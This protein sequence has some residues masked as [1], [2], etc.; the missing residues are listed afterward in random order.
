M[1]TIERRFWNK[2]DWSADESMCWPWLAATQ[3]GY[4]K[5][6]L[7]VFDGVGL[8]GYAHRVAY[9]LEVGPVPEG[10]QLDH[11]CRNRACVNPTHLEPVTARENTRRGEHVNSRKTH[12]PQAHP[13][14]EVNTYFDSLGWRHCRTCRGAR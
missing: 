14:D 6:H 5:F 12:C 3:G 10:L 13:Y 11:L 7:G 1:Q 9:E 8:L 2:V 4:G